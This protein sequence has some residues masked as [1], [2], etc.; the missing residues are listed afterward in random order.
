MDARAPMHPRRPQALDAGLF[1]VV[2]AVPLAFTPF[3]TSPF[4]DPKLLLL[5]LGTLLI[6]LGA[7]PADRRLALAAGAWFGVTALAAVLGVDPQRSLTG[8]EGPLTGLGLFACCAVLVVAGAS[9]TRETIERVGGWLLWTGLIVGAITLVWRLAP[10]VI[11]AGVT[12]L[13]FRGG[14]VGNPVFA[15]A[16]IAGAIAVAL[17]RELSPLRRAVSIVVLVSGISAGGERVAWLL[18]IVAVVAT[19]WWARVDRRRAALLAGGIVAILAGWALAEPVLPE[20]ATVSPVAQVTSFGSDTGRL[21]AFEVHTRAWLDR[22][23]L[24]WGPGTTLSGYRANATAE[25]IDTAGIA[26]DEAHNLV[27]Q[28][29][30]QSGI[31]GLLALGW[32]V[33]IVVSRGLRA[34]R[35]AAWVIGTVTVFA[36]FC[37]FEPFNLS[38][39]P[40]LF[41][42]A[43]AA[44]AGAR[45]A[46]AS[47]RWTRVAYASTGIVLI[48]GLG[49]AALTF[50][51]SA[52]E[53]WGARYEDQPALRT[54]LAL[55]PWRVTA[56]MELL[57]DLALDARSRQVP[58]T[59][60][61]ARELI[62]DLVD[63]RG[64]D[65]RV[66]PAAA[67]A[68][69]LMEDF[70]AARGWLLSQ[71]EVFPG[72]AAILPD[73]DV[74][75]RG[76]VS[77]I[78]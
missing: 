3:T 42:F 29:A 39:T 54:S 61:E 55:Q 16:V 35:D 5:S 24:G 67:D 71:L 32:L 23:V 37:L 60:E 13:D 46:P 69:G 4:A 11:E 31:L 56:G 20:G 77:G 64:W 49:L 70:G 76:E 52:Y 59:D 22:P 62:D 48:A 15:G 17:V 19:L 41:L 28:T 43:G 38:V 74:V 1:L 14:T 40:L 66:R 2:V 53:R 63:D 34:S 25:Q 6:W 21:T 68:E 9:L 7:A 44:G 73:P 78:P 58:G 26:W 30:S 8:L 47:R 18:P 75:G 65:P 12:D 36:V 10:D 27:I 45:E 50:A 57:R 72:D 51:A 33:V